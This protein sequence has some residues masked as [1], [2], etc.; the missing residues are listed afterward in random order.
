MR[1][2]LYLAIIVFFLITSMILGYV[3]RRSIYSVRNRIPSIIADQV[4]QAS[5]AMIVNVPIILAIYRRQGISLKILLPGLA[6]I[7]I[8]LDHILQAGTLDPR[9]ILR[10]IHRFPTHSLT[11]AALLGFMLFAVFRDVEI[12]WMI[13]SGIAAHFLF[14]AASG[15]EIKILYPFLTIRNQTNSHSMR[16]LLLHNHLQPQQ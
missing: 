11:F 7:F 1:K 10:E 16:F 2:I 6:S 3:Y 15:G 9:L 5:V 4:I 8:D 14:D 13:S 12:S